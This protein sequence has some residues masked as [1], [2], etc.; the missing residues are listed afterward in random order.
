MFYKETTPG[1]HEKYDEDW[2]VQ[3]TD[4]I[5]KTLKE[6]KKGKY[7]AELYFVTEDGDEYVMYHNQDCCESVTIEDINGDLDDLVGE[8]IRKAEE[9]SNHSEVGSNGDSVTWTF[10][11][12]ATIN[13]YVTIRWYGTSNGYY[14]EKVDFHKITPNGEFW[15]DQVKIGKAML[16]LASGVRMTK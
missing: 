2:D 13:G 1:H 15:D 12:F 9:T 14:S 10:Y 4:L 5:G 16:G 3:I 11:H 7:N 8:P 6:V